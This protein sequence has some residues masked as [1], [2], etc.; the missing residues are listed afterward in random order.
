MGS[1]EERRAASPQ[2]YKHTAT[3]LVNYP[4]AFAIC[5]P[6][7]EGNRKGKTKKIT[8]GQKETRS[9]AQ[10]ARPIVPEVS[11]VRVATRGSNK[12]EEDSVASARIVRKEHEF[13][14][15]S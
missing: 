9:R 11:L 14:V 12:K 1:S 2:T 4:L 5:L 6:P 3:T 10:A 13:R 8:G 7:C 15:R